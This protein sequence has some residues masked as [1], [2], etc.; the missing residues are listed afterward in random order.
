M[1]FPKNRFL[2]F[3]LVGIF[4]YANNSQAVT[5]SPHSIHHQK[6]RPK[7]NTDAARPDWGSWVRLASV[8]SDNDKQNKNTDC[9]IKNRQ[10]KCRSLKVLEVNHLQKLQFGKFTMNRGARAIVTIDPASGNKTV[11]GAHDSGGRYGPAEFE[12]KG[13]PN[14]EF[15]VTFPGEM[16]LSGSQGGGLRVSKFTGS[17]VEARNQQRT[18]RTI[19]KLGQD[20]RAVLLVGGTLQIPPNHEPGDMSGG[21]NINVEYFP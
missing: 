7:N 10:G 15:V 6:I 12:I 3:L 2:F 14:M 5:P 21:V 16:T 4:F 20:G 19:G 13:E 17:F 1:I 8:D 18:S 9:K 11:T